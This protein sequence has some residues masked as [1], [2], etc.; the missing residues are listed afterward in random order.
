[1]HSALVCICILNKATRNK[2]MSEELQYRVRDLEETCRNIAKVQDSTL[3]ATEALHA[4]MSKA[5]EYSLRDNRLTAEDTKAA[6]NDLKLFIQNVG[7]KLGTRVDAVEKWQD[8]ATGALKLATSTG[9]LGLILK[10]F[11]HN[12]DKAVR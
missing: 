5:Q 7:D 11:G 2:N 12:V 8:R 10:F 4:R 3:K 1:L 6:V 9:I